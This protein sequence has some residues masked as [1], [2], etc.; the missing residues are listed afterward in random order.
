MVTRKQSTAQHDA[1]P[2]PPGL[3]GAIRES[4]QQIWLA[5]LGAFAKAQEEGGKAFEALVKEGSTMQRRSQAV[6]EER[7]AEVTERMSSVASDLSARAAGQWDK[8]EHIFENRVA[9]ALERLGAPSASELD[10]LTARVDALQA[11][12]DA[13]Q[14]PQ[15]AR[16]VTRRTRAKAATETPTPAETPTRPRR[17][18]AAKR[19]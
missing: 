8:L 2:V 4:A 12:L 18:R 14:A 1:D 15:A 5:G 7:L 17:P 11:R 9:R 13:L 16:T 19:D 10:A 6:A 3:S